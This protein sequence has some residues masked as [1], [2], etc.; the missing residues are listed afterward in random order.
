MQRETYNAEKLQICTINNNN[1]APSNAMNM[2]HVIALLLISDVANTRT[3]SNN[4]T[5][6]LDIVPSYKGYG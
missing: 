2:N 4:S 5:L 6:N 3:E 1:H